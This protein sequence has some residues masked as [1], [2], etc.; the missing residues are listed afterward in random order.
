MMALM[1]L[2]NLLTHSQWAICWNALT[3]MCY[4]HNNC[5]S[6]YTTNVSDFICKY[7]SPVIVKIKQNRENQ[8]V[9][10]M[11]D[12]LH[13]NGHFISRNLRDHT[14]TCSVCVDAQHQTTK[15]F[16][17]VKQSSVF[18]T[19]SQFYI[20][21]VHH[22]KQHTYVDVVQGKYK[23]GLVPLKSLKKINRQQQTEFCQWLAGLIDGDGCFL[24][25]K[26]GYT[27]LEITVHT[28]DQSILHA[29]KQKF[30]GSLLPRSGVNAVRYRLHNT[31]GMTVLVN[32]VNGY[33]RHPMRMKQL[34]KV[35]QTLNLPFKNSDKLNPYHGWYA[36]MFDAD[37][38]VT[39]NKKSKQIT[40]SVSQ[41]EKDLILLFQ[42]NFG[43][44]VYFDDCKYKTWKWAVQ[45]K[46]DVLQV[47][48]YFRHFP[49]RSARR[50][51]LLKIPR[52]Y[53]LIKDRAYESTDKCVR[54]RWQY[55][56][57]PW[58]E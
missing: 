22:R 16:V 37:G 53:W 17:F 45:V 18:Q 14:P 8:Q 57:L 6:V 49:C 32:S 11:N 50:I 4:K 20:T 15:H 26:Q 56:I 5:A 30:G 27:S 2:S 29:V 39:L 34:Q 12:S 38:T 48:G 24:V 43:G 46:A 47:V 35:C 1:C 54:N 7:I 33:I 52:L 36:G 40:I 55:A 10:N 31:T 58:N 19:H 44:S 13:I 25:S 21:Q 28:E 42:Q 51:Q 23:Y 9:T 3:V 41:K